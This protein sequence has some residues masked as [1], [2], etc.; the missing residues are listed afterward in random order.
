L[1]KNFADV[2]ADFGSICPKPEKSLRISAKAAASKAK[3]PF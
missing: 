3:M 1:R 2:R